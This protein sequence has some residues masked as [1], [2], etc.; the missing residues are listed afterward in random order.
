MTAASRRQ[1][2]DDYVRAIERI[3]DRFGISEFDYEF[4]NGDHRRVVIRHR[5]QQRF[6][7][8]PLTGSDWRGPLNTAA[9]V[10]RVVREMEGVP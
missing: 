9:R 1:R 5:G 4:T 10:K 8:F 7:V 3:L 6:I 2:R